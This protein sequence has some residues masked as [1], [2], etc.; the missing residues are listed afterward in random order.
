[1]SRRTKPSVPQVSRIPRFFSNQAAGVSFAY[2]LSSSLIAAWS[3]VLVGGCIVTSAEEFP[4]ESQ[5]PPVVLDTPDLPIGSV[6]KYDQRNDKEVR[7]GIDIRDENVDDELKVQVEITVVGQ[8]VPERL[9]PMNMVGRTT[10]PERM[11]FELLIGSAQIKT[12]LCSKVDVWVSQDFAGDCADTRGFGV[13]Q[14]RGD[15]GHAQYLI[16][17]LSGDPLQNAK[18]AQDLIS[19]CPTITPRVSTT[20]MPMAPSP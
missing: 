19:S 8:S 11:E 3:C 10:L 15:L 20:M 16:W 1:M 13:P 18:A 4:E 5:V 9:C 14:N 12:G 7:L 2:K 17:E 6:V